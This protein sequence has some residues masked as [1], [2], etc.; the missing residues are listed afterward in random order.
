LAENIRTGEKCAL[1]IMKKQK[2]RKNANLNLFKNEITV[3]KGVN[4]PNILR[5]IDY[6]DHAVAH[7]PNSK[8]VSVAYIALEFAEHGEL[9]DYISE[10]GKFS[11]PVARFYFRQLID[12]LEFMNTKGYSHRDIKPENILLDSS[13]NLKLGDFG[14]ATKRQVSSSRKGTAGYMA[15][16]VLEGEEYDSRASDVFSAGT[17]LFIILTQFCPFINANKA[18]RYYSKIMAG[19]WDRV[20]EMYES[21]NSNE[22]SFSDEFKDLFQRLVC[23]KP[24]ERLTCAQIKQHRWFDGEIATPQ[25]ILDQFTH[26]KILKDIKLSSPES[27]QEKTDEKKTSANTDN[28]EDKEEEVKKTKEQ[29]PV[30]SKEDKR[31]TK[32][33]NVSDPDELINAVVEFAM[34][35]EYSFDK[36]DEFFRVEL[37]VVEAGES[38]LVTVNVLKKPDDDSRCVQFVRVSGSK[39]AFMA[40]FTYTKL[41]LADKPDLN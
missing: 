7:S 28:S 11:E 27:E 9:F 32:F 37:R 13:F 1:K 5:L 2:N 8:T 23:F 15:P 21:S 41:F 36:S 6:S 40:A 33:F 38:A 35:R 3:L 22:T 14:F 26:R 34:N 17:V 25:E 30:V 31:Y 20:W 4:H 29:K 24:E 16:E 12:C 18:D 39:L 10:T 19:C